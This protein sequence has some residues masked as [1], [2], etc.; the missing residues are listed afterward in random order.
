[1]WYVFRGKGIKHFFAPEL[2][3]DKQTST[4]SVCSLAQGSKSDLRKPKG[5]RE[6]QRCA[7]YL[8]GLGKLDGLRKLWDRSQ[9][10]S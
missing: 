10:R 9:K 6:C 4:I 1:M 7:S 2:L 3:Q 8:Q 5:E